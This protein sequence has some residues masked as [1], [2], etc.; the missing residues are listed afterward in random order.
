MP[1]PTMTIAV[2]DSQH[3]QQTLKT[4]KSEATMRCVHSLR[5]EPHSLHCWLAV[6]DTRRKVSVI[7]EAN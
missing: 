5:V 2:A 7:N 6:T 3:N 1:Q 4:Q